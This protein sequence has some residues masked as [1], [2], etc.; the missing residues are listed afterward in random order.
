VRRLADKLAATKRDLD[1]SNEQHGSATNMSVSLKQ[2]VANLKAYEGV[3]EELELTSGALVDT[4]DE[5]ACARKEIEKSRVRIRVI[6]SE[7]KETNP[8]KMNVLTRENFNLATEGIHSNAMYHD[9][10]V[11]RLAT[12]TRSIYS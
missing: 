6:R 3:S 8:S 9:D 1:K 10:S 2:D 11:D 12:V 7:L 4:K 5:L